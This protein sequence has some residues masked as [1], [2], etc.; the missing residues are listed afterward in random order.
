MTIG[1]KTPALPE[2]DRGIVIYVEALVQDF[3][4]GTEFVMSRLI[5]DEL[6]DFVASSEG[7]KNKGARILIGKRIAEL[8]RERV[9][10][11]LLLIRE[12]SA[13]HKVYRVLSHPNVVE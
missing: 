6:A 5:N 11:C 4:I 12:T 10:T 9:L 3:A 8:T 2:T 7:K 13:N 1:T